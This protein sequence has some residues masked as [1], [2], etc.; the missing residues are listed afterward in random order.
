M[1]RL[2][3]FFVLFIST[4]MLQACQVVTIW[5]TEDIYF[6]DLEP[7]ILL[8]GNTHFEVAFQKSNGAIKYILNKQTQGLISLGSQ[9]SCLWRTFSQT[10]PPDQNNIGGCTYPSHQFHYHWSARDR[11]LNFFY[12][13][14]TQI[15]TQVQFTMSEEPWFDLKLSLQ[16]HSPYPIHDVLFPANLTFQKKNTK[17]L[18]MPIMPGIIFDT[19]FFDRNRAYQDIY[20]GH[21]FAHYLHLQTHQ[22]NFSLYRLYEKDQIQ[23]VRFG[24]FHDDRLGNSSGYLDHTF[25]TDVAPGQAWQTPEMRIHLLATKQA[26]IQ[27]Y[28]DVQRFAQF[29]TIDQ[30]SGEISAQLQAAPLFQLDTNQPFST[31]ITDIEA[32]PVP[33]LLHLTNYWP[34]GF[35]ENYP[36]LLPP[37]PDFGTLA[38]LQ[39]LL[40]RAKQAGHL[41]MPYT[42]P[43][44][45]DDEA[46]SIQNLPDH[47]DVAA[48]AVTDAFN[49]P[50]YQCYSI[51]LFA[52]SCIPEKAGRNALINRLVPYGS[53]HHGGYVVSPY[54]PYVQNRLLSLT[55]EMNAA[56]KPDITFQDQVGARV[57]LRDFNQASPNPS[58]Y[59]QGWLEQT[60]RFTNTRL[61]TEFGVD[62]LAETELGFHGSYLLYQALDQKLENW[63][64]NSWRPYPLA[65][66]LLRDRVLFYQHNVAPETMT[67]STDILRWN[68]AF[69]YM[70][71]Y[72][73]N[74]GF[75]SPWIPL[76]GQIQQQVIAP[77]ATER[78]LDFI[79]LD[80]Q[81]QVSQTTFE[82]V[83]VIANWQ[84]TAPFT[85]QTHTLPPNGVLIIQH[86]QSS[87][88]GLFE[89]FNNVE[90]TDGEHFLIEQRE[91]EAIIIRKPLG[92]ETPLS[93]RSLPTWKDNDQVI[94]N[95]YNMQSALLEQSTTRVSQG[96]IKLRYRPAVKSQQVG[97]Y[98]ITKQN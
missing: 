33:G 96:E 53:W 77:Y 73:L 35:D 58:S 86:D 74:E 39:H 76:I 91:A 32:L 50:V 82:T 59:M 34:V 41:I 37:N 67:T 31:Y 89:Q 6:R 87:I 5:S 68:L 28:R 46:P 25:L 13:K 44:W 38:D 47:V 56:L 75:A 93:I 7:E 15:D 80:D 18:L 30:K 52:P 9:D 10:A 48:V 92:R 26:T 62:R 79:W 1:K 88:A 98:R 72:D 43:T 90:L 2:I 55:Q 36:D 21:L 49:D 27:A 14:Q 71:G 45:W 70:L 60:R 84:A 19:M 97:Y 16:N 81:H 69:G 20:P 66:L 51:S 29:K 11:A 95:I 8:L 4:F 23:P 12:T 24:Y 40:N 64:D 78:M 22:G 17:A 94:V 85:W 65:P 3:F 57:V 42:N 83:T 61:M 54:A 63:D